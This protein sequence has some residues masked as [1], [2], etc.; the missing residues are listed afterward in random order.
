MITIY[1]AKKI[2]SMNP[3][4]PVA[5]HIAVLDEKILG[6]GSYDDLK[7]WGQHRLD[8]R[9]A[10]KIFMPGFIEGHCHAVEGTFWR[11]TYCGY[12]DRLDP[13]GKIWT[14]LQSKQRVLDRLREARDSLAERGAPVT[15]WGFDPIYFESAEFTRKDLDAVSDTSVVA[16]LHASSH[17]LNVNSRVLELAKLLRPS[18][19]HPGVMLGEDGLPT[20]ELRGP[21]AIGLVIHLCGFGDDLLACDEAGLLAFGKLCVRAGVTT[22]T[23]LANPLTDASVDMMLR[24]TS[25]D[26]FPARI[27][28]FLRMRTDY[29]GPMVRRAESL[30]KRTT[31]RLDL[32]RIKLVADGS[33]Q[34]FSARMNWPGYYNGAPNGLW[35]CTPQDVLATFV[36]GLKSDIQIHVHTNGD[37][38]TEMVLQAM[39]QALK[40]TPAHDHRFTIQHCQMATVAMLQKIR[41]FKMCANFF[42]NHLYF[43]G[44]QHLAITLGPE[45]AHRMNPCASALSMDIPVAIHSDAPITPL[46][47]LFTAW[48]ASNRQTVSGVILGPNERLS[49]EQALQSI[50]IGAARTLKLDDQ[51]GSLES[52]KWADITL[53]N[54]DPYEGDAAGL[55]N[56]SVMGTIQSGRVFLAEEL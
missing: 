16:L 56:L 10:D 26:D 43:W 4:Q 37:Q 52:G 29:G 28:P 35:Y 31:P 8:E 53:L 48:C 54:E 38:A 49:M 50:T 2:Y 11:H 19:N 36:E 17:I 7:G 30:K 14:G 41:A 32:G 34:G 45:R 47:P 23:D 21:E 5:T 22:A 1:K 25:S 46:N 13:E 39:E 27:V 15:G 6:V 3:A 9:F 40:I 20:G 44:D 24:V 51:I 12:F 33:I 42:A 55:K 18:I